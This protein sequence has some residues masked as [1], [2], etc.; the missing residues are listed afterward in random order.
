MAEIKFSC[1]N[2]QQHIQADEGYAGV[3][4]NCPACQ[5]G[6]LVPG[7]PAAPPPPPPPL[8]TP[9]AAPAA[10]SASSACPSCGGALPRGAVL[11]TQCG[12]N[13]ATGKRMVAGKVVAPGKPAKERGETP[14]HKTA[15]P[16]VGV[17]VL[18][19]G[20]LYFLGKDNPKVQLAIGAV[21]LLYLVGV[22][23]LVTVSAF[24]VGL[25]TGFLTM[26]VLPFTVYYVFKINDDDSLKILYAAA[27][28]IRF[29]TWF[30]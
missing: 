2:C 3:Q 19:I 21:V 20:I 10:Q 15:Y 11:C 24:Q 12:F 18:A 22:H 4:I 8:P 14:W 25:G 30:L 26:C 16:Y 27:L 9:S 5:T 29:G 28:A 13:L 23:I 7:N 17:V 6:M 1:P